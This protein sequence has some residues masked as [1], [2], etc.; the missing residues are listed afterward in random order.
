MGSINFRIVALGPDQGRASGVVLR[1]VVCPQCSRR[2]WEV[3]KQEG[4]NQ[5]YS[6]RKKI[7][8]VELLGKVIVIGKIQS[9]PETSYGAQ[10]YAN[11]KKIII[12][13]VFKWRHVERT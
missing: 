10:K 7:A 12:I 6:C 13:N 1:A 8:L 11:V 9:K 3:L 5:M 4:H 2:S